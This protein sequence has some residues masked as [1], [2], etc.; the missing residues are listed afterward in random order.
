M[1]LIVIRV[2]S[3]DRIFNP[4]ALIPARPTISN[5][6]WV[7]GTQYITPADLDILIGGSERPPSKRQLQQARADAAAQRADQR[8]AVDRSA[9]DMRAAPDQEGYWEW[10]QR[11]I[12]ERTEKLNIMGDSMDNLQ[13]NSSGFAD[14]VGKYVQKQKRGLVMGAMKSKFGL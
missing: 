5:F 9:A 8:A 14:D 3:N 6:Q 7:S 11:N 2:Q 1:I 13:K 10:A 12:S 4:E